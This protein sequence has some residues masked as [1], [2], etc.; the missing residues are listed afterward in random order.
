[1]LWEQSKAK[2]RYFT[3]RRRDSVS[4]S[5]KKKGVHTP[6]R[7][8]PPPPSDLFQRGRLVSCRYGDAL[9]CD[10]YRGGSR[11][12]HCHLLRVWCGWTMFFFFFPS[13]R[14]GGWGDNRRAP[15]GVLRRHCCLLFYIAII[16][17]YYNYYLLYN[18]FHQ[19][20][21]LLRS[22][23][24][25]CYLFDLQGFFGEVC[26]CLSFIA[27]FVSLLSRVFCAIFRS[28]FSLFL[29]FLFKC[30][31]RCVWSWCVT[32]HSSLFLWRGGKRC[33]SKML[34]RECHPDRKFPGRDQLLAL[35]LS[36]VST[37]V[38][39]VKHRKQHFEQHILWA[40]CLLRNW[41][42]L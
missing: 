26:E 14:R 19:L 42:S 41:H 27:L 25:L 29:L 33:S 7:R 30:L 35:F 2:S 17:N 37:S 21:L 38:S 39:I 28:Y 20:P 15:A 4:I 23:S 34:S 11:E 8:A 40:K 31:S 5:R 1:M 6:R 16:I 18:S 13:A 22:P 3:R 32:T 24:P 36:P 10:T 9:D 12:G